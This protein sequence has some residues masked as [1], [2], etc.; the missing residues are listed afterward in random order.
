M[1]LLR[2]LFLARQQGT[3]IIWRKFVS[4]PAGIFPT[5][6][7][8]E[9]LENWLRNHGA[10]EAHTADALF[11][12]ACERLQSLRVSRYRDECDDENE[13]ETGRHG[14]LF[15]LQPQGLECRD[16]AQH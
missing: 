16:H 7:D 11:D 5:A 10:R 3:I 4:T 2:C 8:K 15:L 14:N 9:E 13:R 1:G 12:S 6:Q